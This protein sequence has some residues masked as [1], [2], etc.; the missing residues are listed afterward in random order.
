MQSHL[1]VRIPLQV[2]TPI[3]KIKTLRVSCMHITQCMHPFSHCLSFGAM[4]DAARNSLERTKGAKEGG[5]MKRERGKMDGRE[6]GREE[7][8]RKVETYSDSPKEK[9]GSCSS[10]VQ[11]APKS[12]LFF[13][14]D[15]DVSLAV[16]PDA[17]LTVLKFPTQCVPYREARLSC[18]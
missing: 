12:S 7:K 10:Q 9:Q 13:P 14:C 6:E 16:N 4:T 17:Y 18:K 1:V 15:G 3:L 8:E 11:V 2:F 5:R